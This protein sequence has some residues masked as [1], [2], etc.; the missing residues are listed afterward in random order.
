MSPEG[1]IVPGELRQN[2]YPGPDHNIAMF[3]EL[4]FERI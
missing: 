3:E 4:E 1:T 2:S